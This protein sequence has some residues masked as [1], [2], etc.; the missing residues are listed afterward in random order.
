M[1]KILMAKIKNDAGIIGAIGDA[2]F[3]S[4]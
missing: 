3:G 2:S 4:F 1:P